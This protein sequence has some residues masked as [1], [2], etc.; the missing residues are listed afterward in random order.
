MLTNAW[1][2]SV[3]ARS[4]G[5]MLVKARTNVMAMRSTGR[6]A[7]ATL[8]RTDSFAVVIR[9]IRDG[10]DPPASPAGSSGATWAAVR[11]RA[12]P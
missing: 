1:A 10:F 5:S 8:A 9:S 12:T 3:M 7:R 2:A 4:N 6:G 11:S